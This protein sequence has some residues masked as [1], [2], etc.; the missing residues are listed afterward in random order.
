MN[1]V[2]EKIKAERERKLL[3]TLSDFIKNISTEEGVMS[4]EKLIAE[5]KEMK[6]KFESEM[7][8]F[9]TAA[10]K[11]F[12]ESIPVKGVHYFDGKDG[13]DGK[14]GKDGISIKG[15][16][17]KDGKDA[18]GERIAER[19][20][21]KIKPPKDGKDADSKEIVEQVLKVVRGK[22]FTIDDIEGLELALTNARSKKHGGQGRTYRLLAAWTTPTGNDVTTSDNTTFTFKNPPLQ[23]ELEVYRG[24]ARNFDENGD[25]SITSAPGGRVASVTLASAVNIAAGELLNFRTRG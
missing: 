16:D 8:E 15:E 11:E 10:K 19:V 4:A 23:S 13:R 20:L 22:K 1:T 21:A 12:R 25:F 7:T 14:N 24:G 3:L 6:D 5:L 2:L 18:D 9:M 17:S